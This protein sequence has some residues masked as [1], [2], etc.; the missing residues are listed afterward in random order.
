[1][2]FEGERY[3]Q[4]FSVITR[5]D[6]GAIYHYQP[7]AVD[8][9]LVNVEIP[10]KL[11]V[12]YI[13]GAGDDIPN[14][15]R[16]IGVNVK[17]ITADELARGDL[18]RYRTIVTGIRAYDV[19]EDVRKNNARLLDFVHGGGTLI[20]QYNTSL[21]DF[22]KGRYTPYPAELGRERV[23]EEQSAVQVLEPKDEIFRVPNQIT[24]DDFG[25]W[26]QERGLYFMHSW[27]SRWQ[28]LLAMHDRGELPLKGGLLRCFYG[29]GT[30][31]YSGLSFFRQ[32]PEGVPGAVRLLV[33]LVDDHPNEQSSPEPRNA[34]HGE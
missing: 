25:G 13:M 6:L 19:R 4:G 10:S 21:A 34:R 33:N 22:N 14:V 27:D 16:Q 2:S 32:L 23:T 1:L 20:V 30:Y 12:G 17:T 29:R 31:I 24:A 7:A 18:R 9:S 8:I 15:L 26:I 3:D 28:P 5:A 11:A